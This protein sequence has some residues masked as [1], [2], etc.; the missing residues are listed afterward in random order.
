DFVKTKLVAWKELM[1]PVFE[2]K[3]Q[4]TSSPFS[5]PNST[6]IPRVFPH[7]TRFGLRNSLGFEGYVCAS[8]DCAWPI[9]GISDWW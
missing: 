6:R 9:F 7:L 2:R 8:G 4:T 3:W 5:P 1:Q